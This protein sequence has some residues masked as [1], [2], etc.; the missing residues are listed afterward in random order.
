MAVLH[1]HLDRDRT[2]P[3][4][5][6]Y[7]R[8][9]T[10]ETFLHFNIHL[11]EHL[12]LLNDI[13]IQWMFQFPWPRMVK[14]FRQAV[15][16]CMFQQVMRFVLR[17]VNHGVVR[18]RGVVEEEADGRKQSE[19]IDKSKDDGKATAEK[20][21]GTSTG[22]SKL[23]QSSNLPP[24]LKHATDTNNVAESVVVVVFGIHDDFD[25]RPDAEAV[26]NFFAERRRMYPN[27]QVFNISQE[28]VREWV[29][30]NIP[31]LAA[32]N[33]DL[34]VWFHSSHGAQ[35]KDGQ[36]VIQTQSN[37]HN[38]NDEDEFTIF[39]A[40]DNPLGEET[41]NIGI[42][43]FIEHH[44]HQQ[45]NGGTKR[46]YIKG[47]CHTNDNVSPVSLCSKKKHSIVIPETPY[48]NLIQLGSSATGQTAWP[49]GN[50]GVAPFV[51]VM[52]ERY[53]RGESLLH[54]V[55]QIVNQDKRQSKLLEDVGAKTAEHGS[56]G[57]GFQLT[58]GN[59]YQDLAL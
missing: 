33:P 6:S 57:T 49:G 30:K 19:L 26:L 34:F 17:N 42:F 29:K 28:D 45:N 15:V 21:S 24:E 13:E 51:Q 10:V 36:I 25:G 5:T 18:R 12:F 22:G 3:R 50:G 27:D 39:Q 14:R 20:T 53:V 37:M 47:N 58:I 40:K 32:S 1:D 16:F 38:Q 4:D 43:D 2:Q 56:D 59:G 44:F 11:L 31:K 41:D 23:N 55:V 8:F 52:T 9:I 46:L 7:L 35:N 48:T 54:W